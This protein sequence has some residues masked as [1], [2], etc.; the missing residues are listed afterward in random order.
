MLPVT[1]SLFLLTIVVCYCGFLF[2][3]RNDVALL[4]DFVM[5]FPKGT[6]MVEHVLKICEKD[7]NIDNVYL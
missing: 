1:K 4:S 7:G 5:V 2:P 6:V 3:V